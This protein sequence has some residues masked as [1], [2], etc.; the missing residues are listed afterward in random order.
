ME[1]GMDATG[2]FTHVRGQGSQ[3]GPDQLGQLPVLD[4][5]G[6]NGRVESR[7]ITKFLQHFQICAGGP[8]LAL[9]DGLQPKGFK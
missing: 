6:R 7:V 4:H 5:Q 8:A 9:F 2:G 3:V 1:R